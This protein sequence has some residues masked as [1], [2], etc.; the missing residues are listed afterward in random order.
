MIILD[1]LLNK[2]IRLYDMFVMDRNGDIFLFRPNEKRRI[3]LNDEE[4]T[5]QKRLIKDMY[6]EGGSKLYSMARKAAI[7]KGCTVKWVYKK[8]EEDWIWATQLCC[9]GDKK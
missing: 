1:R 3:E 5:S 8:E 7:A 9:P 6:L 2:K 4:Y